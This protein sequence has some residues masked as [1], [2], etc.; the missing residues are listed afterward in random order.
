MQPPPIRL[1]MRASQRPPC[2]SHKGNGRPGRQEAQGSPLCQALPRKQTCGS[3][4]E[5]SL[6]AEMARTDLGRM[7]SKEAGLLGKC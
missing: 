7:T 5:E 3:R 2:L 4:Q 6:L 1:S